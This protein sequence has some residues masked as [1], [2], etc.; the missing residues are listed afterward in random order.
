MCSLP[1]EPL[2]RTTARATA[3]ISGLG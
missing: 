1:S 2:S 3:A